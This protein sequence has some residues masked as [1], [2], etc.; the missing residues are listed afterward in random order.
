MSLK[1]VSWVQSVC[2]RK[3]QP[4]TPTDK[5]KKIYEKRKKIRSEQKYHSRNMLYTA[6]YEYTKENNA[7][8]YQRKR[9]LQM[10]TSDYSYGKLVFLYL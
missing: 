5:K 1:N 8:E 4:M 2:L 9:K 10:N 7:A 6:V 3:T